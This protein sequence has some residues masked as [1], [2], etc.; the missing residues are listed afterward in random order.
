[1]GQRT[2]ILGSGNILLQDEGLGV[3]AVER[4]TSQYWLPQEVQALD[5]GVVGLALLPYLEGVSSLLVLDAIQAGQQPGTLARLSDHGLSAALSLKTS[6]HQIGLQELLATGSLLGTLPPHVVLWGMEP[7]SIE[8][9]IGLTPPVAVHLDAL[10]G[11]AV[12][13]LRDWGFSV[14]ERAEQERARLSWR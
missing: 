5:G 13:E 2:L 3:H 8:W 9:G 6:M 11:A 14:K 4:L 7:A 10:V 12:Q 1:M